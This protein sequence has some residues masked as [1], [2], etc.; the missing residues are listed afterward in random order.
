MSRSETCHVIWQD[1]PVSQSVSSHSSVEEPDVTYSNTLFRKMAWRPWA[2]KDEKREIRNGV[3]RL[4]MVLLKFK[5]QAPSAELPCQSIGMQVVTTLLR[6][7]M[8]PIQTH[9]SEKW[10]E[11][12]KD[13]KREIRNGVPRLEMVLLKAKSQAPSAELTCSLDSW[14]H[15]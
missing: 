2:K 7:Q 6:N 9:Y 4:E 1:S 3:P 13:E 11:D 14:T 12:K 10:P 8:W 5:S 15:T